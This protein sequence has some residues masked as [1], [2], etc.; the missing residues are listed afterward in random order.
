M[1]MENCILEA[2]EMSSVQ[3]HI[4][5]MQNIINRMAQNSMQCKQWCIAVE[6]VLFGIAK[7]AVDV[8]LLGIVVIVSLMFMYMDASYLSFERQF[9]EQQRHLIDKINKGE[10][11]G[12]DLFMVETTKKDFRQIRNA[13]CSFSV[14]I[15]Y[16][17]I[18]IFVFVF[19]LMKYYGIFA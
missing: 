4:T 14:W 17:T 11:F 1:I 8:W 6:T 15:Y 12:K 7:D 18:I 10:P 16:I 2:K 13:A 5:M 9:K 19:I 3:A